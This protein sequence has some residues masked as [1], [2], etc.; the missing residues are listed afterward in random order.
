MPK[1]SYR[2]LTEDAPTKSSTAS[3]PPKSGAHCSR[4]REI[5]VRIPRSLAQRRWSSRKR[6]DNIA[7]LD[8]KSCHLACSSCSSPSP[9]PKLRAACQERS[10][11]LESSPSCTP[12]SFLVFLDSS[13]E[14]D[15]RRENAVN[16]PPTDV[17][18]PCP[19]GLD[20][21]SILE[22]GPVCPGSPPDTPAG[23]HDVTTSSGP[24]CRI[25]HEGDQHESLLSLCKCSGTMGLLHLSCLERWLNGRHVDFCELCHHRFPTVA[26]ANSGRLFVHWAL[27]GDSLRT[28]LGDLLCFALLTPVAAV[29]CFLCFHNA[30]KQ[31]LEGRVMEAASLVTLAGLLVTAYIAWSF[32][33]LRFHCR[34]FAVWQS[35]NPVRRVLAPP[36]AREAGERDRTT[37]TQPPGAREM[38]DVVAGSTDETR[39][40]TEPLGGGTVR[41]P[42]ERSIQSGMREDLPSSQGQPM[43][44]LEPFTGFAYW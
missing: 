29:S 31:A 4:L 8:D 23:G 1:N 5:S 38:V 3:A 43:H 41:L 12:K 40:A 2:A 17:L 10:F 33:T 16:V 13:P 27:H 19:L 11:D 24:I 20:V 26:Q 39:S 44:A 37:C 34:T 15:E 42:F 35:R 32:L 7:F 9:P 18:E 30:S 21:T 14:R 6:E 28:L 36:F 22:S 25:C